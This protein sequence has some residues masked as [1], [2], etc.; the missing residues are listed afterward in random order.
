MPHY[1]EFAVPSLGLKID[2]IPGRLNQ[3]SVLVEREGV[4]YRQCSE[5]CGVHLP[6]PQYSM[7]IISLYVV[8]NFTVV[9]IQEGIPQSIFLESMIFNENRETS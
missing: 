9:K 3:T 1:P 6:P 4:Y 7:R 5:I 2:A 8:I